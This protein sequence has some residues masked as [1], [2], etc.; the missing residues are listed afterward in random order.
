MNFPV[1][2]L[3]ILALFDSSSQSKNGWYKSNHQW[4]ITIFVQYW[5]LSLTKF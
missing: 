4:W 3:K 2:T 1:V 5:L